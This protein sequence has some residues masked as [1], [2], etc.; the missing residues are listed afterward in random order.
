MRRFSCIAF[1]VAFLLIAV[2]GCAGSAQTTT[3]GGPAATGETGN[4]D[5]GAPSFSDVQP[6]IEG[7]FVPLM[8]EDEELDASSWQ[9]LIEGSEHGTV[10]IPGDAEH[11][12]LVEVAE[13]A[14][15]EGR[16][17]I[18]AGAR[19]DGGARPYADVQNRLYV[20]N[21][22]GAL[23]TIIDASENRVIGTVDLTERGFG[24]KAKP[25][26]TAVTPSGDWYVSLIGANRVL[27]LNRENEIIGR[28]ET[29]VPGLM[30]YDD[31]SGRLFVGRSMSAVNPPKRL[32]I[33]DGSEMSLRQVGVFLPRPHAL[34]AD[35]QGKHVYIASLAQNR[36]AGVDAATG[37]TKLTSM[38]GPVNT[39]VHFA[40][41]PDGQTLAAGGQTSGTFFFFDVS[42]DTPLTPSVTDSLQL[43]GQP[44]HPSY[45]PS[46]D[47]LYVPQKAASTVSVIDAETRDVTATIRHE[48]LAQ[49]HGSAVRPD[50]RY[51]YVTGSNV[52]GA[53]TPRYPA[54]YGEENRGVV[55]VID[56]HTNEVV[57]VLPADRDPSGLSVRP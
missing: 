51:V 30:E 22:A 43:G 19:S 36:I 34:A 49:P 7:T 15:A 42:P 46:G 11:S 44:W 38:G 52:D 24:P 37:E 12:L 18:D 26:D 31:D 8:T 28:V 10:V 27:K 39:L 35:P 20:A 14:R 2:A 47:R 53:Y 48:A 17:W 32:A 50:G 57:S 56:T 6:L 55:A 4:A 13:H 1:T 40:V 5:R 9:R 16:A 23:V 29:E 54:V 45:T 41:R 33:L 25:H 21:E 3:T